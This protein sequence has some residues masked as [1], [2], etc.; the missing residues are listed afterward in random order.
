MFTGIV[1]ETGMVRHLDGGQL[2]VACS[3]VVTDASVGDSIAV[4]GVCLTVVER[5][6]DGF[7]AGLAP[8][9]LSRT[10]L[11][12][13]GAGDRVN[14]ERS[15]AAD[16]RFGGHMVQG[17]I[18]TTAELVERTVDGDSLRL[19]FRLDPAYVR[20]V[21]PK[22]YVA[23]DGTSLT[24]VDA[25]DDGFSVM[26][27]AFTQQMVTLGT[28]PVGYRANIE[29]DIVGRYMERWLRHGWDRLT[30]TSQ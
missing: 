5:S 30:G 3:L 9:T 10:N 22:G 7:R 8:E 23:I 16:G 14:L 21:V 28:Q 20:Y 12:A 13:L 18:E 29:T 24:V 15:M 25:R 27:I 11:G 17:H 6:A 4:N 2:D 1:E 19:S 26:L